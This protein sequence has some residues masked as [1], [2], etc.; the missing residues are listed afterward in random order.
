MTIKH[1]Q[2]I[3]HNHF[4]KD[5]Q[6][7][8]RCHFDQPG[9]KLRRRNARHAKAVAVA[10]RPVDKLR[11]V[12]RC[13]G[14]KYNRRVRAGRGFSLAELKEAGIP[15]KLAPTIGISV[16][17]RRANLSAEGL[18]SNVE[19]LK[20]YQAR[21]ILFPR[22]S[23]QHKT[24]DASKEEIKAAEEEHGKIIKNLGKI[25]PIENVSLEDAI[26]EVKTSDM[27]EGTTDAYA[28]LRK[29]RSDARLVG[30]REKRAK[31]KAE[32]D[33]APKK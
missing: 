1:N 26:G 30:V 33:S 17:P 24:L 8:V 12:V 4:R 7:R 23:G 31:A 13:P 19:R 18:A 10:P 21:L 15:R 5:W 25:L 29:A 27:G 32:G 3:Q 9:R 11:P 28:T 6:R 2:Q 20:A 14:I 16:D 22:K